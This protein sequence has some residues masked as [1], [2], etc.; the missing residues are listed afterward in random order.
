MYSCNSKIINSSIENEI[1]NVCSNHH[2][3][4]KEYFSRAKIIK[5]LP[6]PEFIENEP[7]VFKTVNSDK[8]QKVL[9]HQYQHDNLFK[10][11]EM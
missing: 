10:L 1:F 5:N 11:L 2:P 6:I 9:P 4:R 3:T 8:L 7:L